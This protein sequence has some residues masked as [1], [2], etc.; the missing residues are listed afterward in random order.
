MNEKKEHKNQQAVEHVHIPGPGEQPVEHNQPT[1]E[2]PTNSKQ[3][4]PADKYQHK[5]EER[6]KK[7][8]LSDF[9]HGD[10]YEDYRQQKTVQEDEKDKRYQ[11]V[12]GTLGDHKHPSLVDQYNE[13][14][15]PLIHNMSQFSQF[16]IKENSINVLKVT[17]QAIK[18]K[19]QKILILMDLNKN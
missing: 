13:G 17:P 18:L 12:L 8:G 9:K 3:V 15:I 1:I 11:K 16:K 2:Y 14:L 4:H 7:F 5:L 6:A 10:L 19:R